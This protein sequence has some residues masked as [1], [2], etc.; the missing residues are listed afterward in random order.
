MIF[1]DRH[2]DQIATPRQQQ[3]LA[4]M[5]R[6]FVRYRVSSLEVFGH[7]DDSETTTSDLHLGARRAEAV[8][9]SLAEAGIR[10]EIIT[11]HD[12]G[13][14]TPL[15]P[16]PPGTPEPQN[17]RVEFR[18]VLHVSDEE[19]PHKRE[20]EDWLR[21]HATQCEPNTAAPEVPQAC[22]EVRH[23]LTHWYLPD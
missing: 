21:Q 14:A 17:R 19:L 16:R 2:S 4:D 13:A 12:S 5:A 10:P 23:A 7:T 15:V 20:C 8:R 22:T 18:P 9:A 11:I 6:T 1:F 3:V